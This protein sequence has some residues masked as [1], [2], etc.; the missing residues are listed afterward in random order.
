MIAKPCLTCNEMTHNGSRCEECEALRRSADNRAR[1]RPSKAGTTTSRGYGSD[2]QRLSARARALQPFC[3][4]CGSPDDL[5]ADHT[6]RAWARREA[7]LT[8][9]LSDVVVLCGRCNVRAG[10]ARPGSE[11][12]RRA[13]QRARR[14]A[15]SRRRRKGG[16]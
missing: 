8:V 12:Y 3:T 16:G 1:A 2:W 7:G 4:A 9:R 14:R 5:Q 13:E 6:P 11:R 10:E 15:R